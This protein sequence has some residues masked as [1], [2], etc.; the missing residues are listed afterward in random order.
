V[1]Y[2]FFPQQAMDLFDAA[3]LI[4]GKD[5]RIPIADLGLASRF[6]SELIPKVLG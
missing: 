5:E 6:Y 4:H 2:G 3:P 1:A